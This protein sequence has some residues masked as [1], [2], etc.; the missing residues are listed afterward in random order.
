MYIFTKFFDASYSQ[1]KTNP[2]RQF[3]N[4]KLKLKEPIKIGLIAD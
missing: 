1:S 3:A 4:L 2:E